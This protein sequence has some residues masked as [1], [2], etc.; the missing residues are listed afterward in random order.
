MW[1]HRH[2]LRERGTFGRFGLPYLL[3]FQVLLPA[4]APL[5]DIF[6]LYG[7]LFLSP[8]RVAGY[9]GG[10]LA[11]QLVSAVYAFRLDRE[12]LRPLWTLALQQVVYRQLMYLVVIQSVAAAIRGTPLRWHKLRRTGELGSARQAAGE[13]LR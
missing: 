8:V 9:W 7:L 6:A 11:L 5:I 1:K 12:R 13:G 3:M 10:F 4:L 2:A